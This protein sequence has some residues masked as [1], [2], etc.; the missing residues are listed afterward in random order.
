[1]I[2]FYFSQFIRII[3]LLMFCYTTY[4]KLTDLNK[5]EATLFKSTLIE[6][7]QVKYL[8]LIIPSIELIAIFSLLRINYRIGFFISF[9]LMLLFTLYL[10]ALNNY[11]FYKGCSC[12]GIFNEL[13]YSQHIIVNI[14]FILLSGVGIF[15]FSVARNKSE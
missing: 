10:V 12:G 7:Y 11:S 13:S 5:F 15:I 1:M 3:L 6:E 8:L 2:R 14:S 9:F 4:H